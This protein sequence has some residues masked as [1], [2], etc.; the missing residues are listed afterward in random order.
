MIFD[1]LPLNQVFIVVDVS[2]CLALDKTA[3]VSDNKFFCWI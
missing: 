3:V 2:D 1:L